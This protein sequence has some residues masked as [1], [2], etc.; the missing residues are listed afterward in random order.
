MPLAG[1]NSDLRD[2]FVFRRNSQVKQTD[3]N[4]PLFETAL[5]DGAVLIGQD[6]PAFGFGL[7]TGEA[8]AARCPLPPARSPCLIEVKAII[9]C[10]SPAST[11]GFTF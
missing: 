6:V 5:A 10:K 7:V 2:I 11:T 3:I 9:R 1:D 8:G 4:Q